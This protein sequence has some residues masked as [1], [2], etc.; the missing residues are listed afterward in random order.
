MNRD[1]LKNMELSTVI[2]N[3]G[4]ML[5]NMS[6]ERMKNSRAVRHYV[7]LNYE[8]HLERLKDEMMFDTAHHYRKQW[9]KVTGYEL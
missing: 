8:A 6:N 3:L 4:V 5:R 1:D 2:D 9:E 7:G